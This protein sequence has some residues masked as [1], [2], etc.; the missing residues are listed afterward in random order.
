MHKPTAEQQS[1]IDAATGT[2]DNLIINAYAGAAKTT[3][4]FLIADALAKSSP[5]MEILCLAFNKKIA[6]EMSAKLPPS[7]VCMTLNGLGHRV[8]SQAL[9]GKRLRVDPSKTYKIMKEL[10]EQYPRS[11]KNELY[12]MMSVL[13]KTVDHAKMAGMVPAG[14]WEKRGKPICTQHDYFVSQEYNFTEVEEEV[15]V[16]TLSKSIDSAFKGYCDFNDQI[17]MPTIFGGVFPYYKLTMVDEA[18][19]LSP[20]NHVMLMKIVGKRRLIAVGDECQAIYGFRG[21]DDDS[22]TS[23]RKLFDMKQMNLTISFRCPTRV[24]EEAQWRAPEMKAPEWAKEGKVEVLD[25]WS[26]DDL[27]ENATI[28]CR[29]NSPLFHIAIKL[30]REGR[31]VELGGKDIIKTLTKTMLK[32]GESSMP[33]DSIL[34]AI[35]DWENAEKAKLKKHAWDRIEDYAQCMRLFAAQGK[36]LGDAIYYAQHISEMC[37][38]LKLMTI[39]KSKGL[40]FDNVYILDESLIQRKGQDLNVRYVAITRAIEKL[41]YIT[42][43]GYTPCRK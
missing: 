25:T 14:K 34:D 23:L 13:M 22:M 40:E 27:E 18:Q 35:D 32:F 3:T 5:K 38:P 17:Y 21:A 4:L 8:W 11:V 19:D 43:E 26:A 7:C 6:A 10:I 31:A 20:L 41:T 9:M 12:P 36:T 37:A 39:H 1:I 30:L 42:T 29:N 28:L 15:I 33:R 2:T 16:N 24:V